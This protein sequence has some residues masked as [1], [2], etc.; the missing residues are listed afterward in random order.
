MAHGIIGSDGTPDSRLFF[1]HY[2]TD[3]VRVPGSF[4]SSSLTLWIRGRIFAI[5]VLSVVGKAGA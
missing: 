5:G 2:C 1:L 4:V 3:R